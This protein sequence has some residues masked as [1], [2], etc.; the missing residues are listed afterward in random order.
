[1]KRDTKR[2]A[3]WN[4]V[5]TQSHV[6]ALM[7]TFGHFHDSCIKGIKYVSGAFVDKD[8]SMN[9]VNNIRTAEIVF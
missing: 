3:K 8:L 1:M 4:K 2:I 7:T 6:D 9:P 5:E